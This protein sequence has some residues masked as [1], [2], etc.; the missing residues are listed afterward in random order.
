MRLVS[1]LFRDFRKGNFTFGPFGHTCHKSIH[2]SL[3]ALEVCSA[4]REECVMEA[5]NHV[6]NF[7]LPVNT[8]YRYL[9]HVVLSCGHCRQSPTNELYPMSTRGCQAQARVVPSLRTFF[10]VSLTD[11]SWRSII[12][13]VSLLLCTSGTTCT[14]YLMW[15][16][17]CL[18]LPTAVRST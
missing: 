4:S 11:F 15:S 6:Q 10:P 13:G 16:V 3:L 7:F 8:S 17:S 12:V 1:G 9:L 18:I 5:N 14:S 2:S